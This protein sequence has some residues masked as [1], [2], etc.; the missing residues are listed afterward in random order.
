MIVPRIAAALAALLLTAASGLAAEPAEIEVSGVWARASAG[1]TQSGAA[2]L[3]LDNRGPTDDRLLGVATPS[4]K[5]AQLHEMSM[6]KDNVMHMRHVQGIALPAG[7]TVKL[8]PGGFH[9]MLMGL[10]APLKAG[11]TFPLT[12]RFAKSGERTVEVTVMPMGAAG[13]AGGH[14]GHTG[15][16]GG[17]GGMDQM[18]EGGGMG[19][20]PGH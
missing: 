20:T 13:P 19:H 4:A 16:M 1:M 17:M 7:K 10:T 6:D 14:M 5:D 12:L 18:H 3:T 8:A 9:V 2:Y 11:D 15:G